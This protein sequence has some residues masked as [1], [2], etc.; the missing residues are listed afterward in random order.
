M[1]ETCGKVEG[2]SF[3]GS[4]FPEGLEEFDCLAVG[5]NVEEAQ[6]F[7]LNASGG[8]RDYRKTC[9]VSGSAAA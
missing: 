7:Y 3:G 1:E 4:L 9:H 5:K 8:R 2:E 6:K